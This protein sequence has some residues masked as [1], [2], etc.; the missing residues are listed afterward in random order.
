M[1]KFV[2]G[3]LTGTSV[4]IATIAGIVYGVK[5]TII[6]PLEEKEQQIDDNRRKAM[7]KSRAR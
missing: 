6:E 1:K 7:R 5:K 4:T 2:S 3:F